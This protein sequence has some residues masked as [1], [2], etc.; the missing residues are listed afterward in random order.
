MALWTRKEAYGKATGLGVNY[1]MNQL[2]LAGSAGQSHRL[3]FHGLQNQ[4]PYQLLQFEIGPSLIASTVYQGIEQF[5][6]KAF[7]PNLA[8]LKN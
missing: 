4:T 6:I 5:K 7:T 8:L 1:K 3:S 2:D